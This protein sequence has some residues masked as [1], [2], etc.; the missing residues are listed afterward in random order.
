MRRWYW[1]HMSRGLD[2]RMTPV[3]VWVSVLS[4]TSS[5]GPGGAEERKGLTVALGETAMLQ[6]N[7]KGPL[8]GLARRGPT[9]HE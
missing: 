9:P 1:G 6:M 3:S 4:I 2:A 7:L 5:R 8:L